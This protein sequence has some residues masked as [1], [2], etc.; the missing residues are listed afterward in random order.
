MNRQAKLD[1]LWAKVSCLQ[2]K[3]W[4]DSEHRFVGLV[5]DLNA[6]DC[7]LEAL[8]SWADLWLASAQEGT[9]ASTDS[10]NAINAA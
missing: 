4:I 6:F 5:R 1:K 3:K 10:E 2:G 9:D 8:N 7:A